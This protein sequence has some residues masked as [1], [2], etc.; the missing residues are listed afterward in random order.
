MSSGA[1]LRPGFTRDRFRFVLARP[2][3]AMRVGM[4]NTTVHS[5][6]QPRRV[7]VPSER[8]RGLDPEFTA[9]PHSFGNDQVVGY[10][11]SG[12]S[13]DPED[14]GAHFLSEA[15]EQGDVGPRDAADLD[16]SLLGDPES[17][18]RPSTE[19]SVWTRM[20]DL[21]T[22]GGGASEQLREAA[23]FGADALEAERNSGPA[24]LDAESE[25]E[26]DSGTI[27]LTDSAIRERSLM[28]S[29]GPAL[30]EV[31]SPDVD[32]DDTGHHSRL[33]SR[34]SLGDQVRGTPEPSG[35]KVGGRSHQLRNAAGSKL[36]KAARKVKNLANRLKH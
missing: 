4:A 36:R 34:E 25:R 3:F 9:Q 30:D 20:V 26:E 12:L 32:A 10:D 23:V 35:Q 1:K 27:R 11:E 16:L 6:P 17:D 18:D 8:A 24:E 19:I 7:R 21:A 2:G 28:D 14:L 22:E 15:V 33:T 13:I 29:E 5:H 31:V